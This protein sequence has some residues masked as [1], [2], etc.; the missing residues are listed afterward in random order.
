MPCACSRRIARNRNAPQV[1]VP[2]RRSLAPYV[3]R[4]RPSSERS[5]NVE[6]RWRTARERTGFGRLRAGG[7]FGHTVLWCQAASSLAAVAHVHHEQI[8]FGSPIRH[9]GAPVTCERRFWPPISDY[10]TGS[11]HPSRQA[12]ERRSAHGPEQQSGGSSGAETRARPV[13]DVAGRRYHI[14]TLPR[15]KNG[16]TGPITRHAGRMFSNPASSCAQARTAGHGARQPQPAM[17]RAAS[18]AQ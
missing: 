8:N 1:G 18:T 16:R 3:H 10:F 15:P 5:A 9:E 7:T 6:K 2:F 14:V 12:A 11:R 13:R 4:A 17:S